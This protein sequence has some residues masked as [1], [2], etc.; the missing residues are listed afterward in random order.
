MSK[1]IV[2]Y[3]LLISCPGDVKNEITLIKESVDE[4]NEKFSDTLGIMIQTRY[5]KT[6]SYSQS[7][8]KP[9]EL[10][11]EQFVKNCDAAVAVFWTRF[12]TPTDQYGSGTEEEIEIM[13]NAG[14][15]VFMYFSEKP[16]SP[17]TI[18]YDQYNKIKNFKEK[19]KNKGMFFQY[20]NDDD[21]RK[22][23][24]S[25]LTKFFLSKMQIDECKLMNAPNLVL[26]GI[27]ENKTIEDI[28]SIRKFKTDNYI[29]IPKQ[30]EKIKQTYKSISDIKIGN[31]CGNHNSFLYKK[32][33]L[34]ENI[35]QILQ[36][37]AEYLNIK[38]NDDFF[39]LGNLYEKT[40]SD[41]SN[42]YIR[43]RNYIG[44][45]NERLKYQLINKLYIKICNLSSW[46]P[47]AN[48]LSSLNYTYL[49]LENNGT[50]FDEDVEILIYFNKKDL[51]DTSERP[52][53]DDNTA[54][55]LI[56]KCNLYEILEIDKCADY[57]SY[58]DSVK[59]SKN[60]PSV[61][62]H[63]D[64]FGLNQRNY[65]KEYEETF[66]DALQYEIF[67]KNNM[68]VLKLQIDYIKHNSVIAFPAPIFLKGKP[69][70]LNYKISSRHI[71]DV[72]TGTIHIKDDTMENTK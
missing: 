18:D 60:L 59:K 58:S 36:E 35:K 25:H 55:Y 4:F 12:G 67:E 14:K 34:E 5:W 10:L 39:C 38:L 16:I 21:F 32:V 70:E 63:V 56:N 3:D 7:G 66:N 17:S 23:F 40:F 49:A 31:T 30:L 13:L 22:L 54:E 20:A 46:L 6:S 37:F 9:Q 69:L 52:N 8:K 24:F 15:Q 53:L 11:N 71:S 50:T 28:A 41:L 72:I 48:A 29:D 68:K 2:K 51:I 47:I 45:K 26:K 1:N 43:K 27:S 42:S 44:D 62:T 33:E 57:L 65:Q 64:L 19:Y 61:R